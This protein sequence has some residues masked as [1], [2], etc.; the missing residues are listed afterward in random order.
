MR[1]RSSRSSKRNSSRLSTALRHLPLEVFT[2]QKSIEGLRHLPLLFS[3]DSL[4][5]IDHGLTLSYTD[6]S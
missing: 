1:T 2:F 5:H 4:T 6:R 3:S